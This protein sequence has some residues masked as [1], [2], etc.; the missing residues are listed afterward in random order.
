M[1]GMRNVSKGR[2]EWWEGSAA[3]AAA[4]PQGLGAAAAPSAGSS[5]AAPRCGS[6]G[7]PSNPSWRLS[8]CTT[9]ET[10]AV[11]LAW[12]RGGQRGA[13]GK[14]GWTVNAWQH[15]SREARRPRPHLVGGGRRHRLQL[16]HQLLQRALQQRRLRRAPQRRQAALAAGKAGTGGLRS[17][18]GL[19]ERS[20]ERHIHRGSLHHGPPLRRRCRCTCHPSSSRAVGCRRRRRHRRRSWLRNIN[21]GAAHA[22]PGCKHGTTSGLLLRP[23]QRAG[24]ASL[25]WR[26]GAGGG[27]RDAGGINAIGGFPAPSMERQGVC[28]SKRFRFRS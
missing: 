25:G 16:P 2:H 26:R 12:A 17:R 24:S 21:C 18:V 22:A 8:V 4:E 28:C 9:Y 23:R 6:C 1:H 20:K 7:M 13:R 27:N 11:G 10:P 5:G 14:E 19:Q 3:A 15:G